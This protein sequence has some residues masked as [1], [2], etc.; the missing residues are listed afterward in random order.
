MAIRKTVL[1]WVSLRESNEYINFKFVTSDK[2]SVPCNEQLTWEEFSSFCLLLQKV[3]TWLHQLLYNDTIIYKTQDQSWKHPWLWI[4]TIH[5]DRMGAWFGLKG[6]VAEETVNAV[7]SVTR[8]APSGSSSITA[9]SRTVSLLSLDSAQSTIQPPSPSKI[10]WL[11]ES[12]GPE[13]RD[14]FR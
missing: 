3:E 5:F 7:S 9:E 6:T 11:I 1:R 12:Y 10:N 13:W 14:L 8:D 2:Q 4:I